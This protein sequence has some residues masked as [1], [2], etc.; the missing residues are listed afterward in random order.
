MRATL[1]R[2]STSLLRKTAVAA[3][4]Y[5]IP[6]GLCYVRGFGAQAFVLALRSRAISSLEGR[7]DERMGVCGG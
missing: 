4:S 6:M 7:G 1:P 5:P 3:R 2:I